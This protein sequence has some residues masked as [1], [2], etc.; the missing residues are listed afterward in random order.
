VPPSVGHLQLA[1]N[2]ELG[3]LQA[4]GRIDGTEDEDGQDD[5]EVTH[6][7]PK[8]Q[9]HRQG[10]FHPH[11]PGPI[12]GQLWQRNHSHSPRNTPGSAPAGQLGGTHPHGE[13]AAALE[14]LE[15]GAAEEG[16]SKEE[17]GQKSNV[18]HILAAGPQEVASSAQALG[19]AQCDQGCR[20]L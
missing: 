12:P 14:M 7:L 17:E 8:L 5:G 9:C 11:W 6:Q 1:G 13:V 3:G 19:P 2:Q 20:R 10:S 15:C 16:A 4:K 18:R